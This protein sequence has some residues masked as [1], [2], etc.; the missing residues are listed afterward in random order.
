M[1][2]VVIDDL[3]QMDELRSNWDVV[4]AA[5]SHASIFLSWAW[6]RGFFEVTPYRWF[7]LALRPDTSAPSVAF[8]PLAEDNSKSDLVRVFRM[9]GAPAADY[10]GLVS[11]PD[12]EDAAISYFSTYIQQELVWDRFHASDV[13]DHRVD[14]VVSMFSREH[15]NIQV[16]GGVSCPYISLPE[17]WDHYLKL[18]SRKRRKSLRRSLRKI[19]ASENFSITYAS[20]ENLTSQIEIF[21]EL[22][23]ERWGVRPSWYRNIFQQCSAEN[24]LL[25]IFLWDGDVPVA[26]SATF[27]DSQK[28]ICYDFARGYRDGYAR[29]SPGNVVLLHAIQYAIENQ[30]DKFDFLRGG[31]SYKYSFGAQ[32]RCVSHTLLARKNLRSALVNRAVNWV[33]WLRK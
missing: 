25:L 8:F 7:V 12:Y 14:A 32:D 20:Q 15:F 10:T 31:E 27:V 11:L 33:R 5:D 26:A 3:Q 23:R 22:W 28:K 19:E 29:Y 1:D 6:L 17:S 21:Y 9:G 4:Y 13:L 30:Y 24:K 18:L 16:K 2:V